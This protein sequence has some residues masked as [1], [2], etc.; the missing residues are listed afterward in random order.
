MTS[1]TKICYKYFM[2]KPVILF[3]SYPDFNGN[4]LAI[5]EELVKRRYD[6]K[7][8]LVWAVYSDFNLKTSYK[9]VKFF[10]CNS[11]EKQDIIRR[12]KCIIDS[13]RYIPKFSKLVY[14]F[15]VRHGCCL[16]NSVVYNRSVGDLD[17]ILTT[18]DEMLKLDQQI[19]SPQIRNKFAVLGMPVTDKLF[20]PKDMYSNGF[21]KELTG[22]G[23]KF[24]KIISWLPTYR[25]HRFKHFS[26]NRF[27]FGIPAVHNIKEYESINETLKAKNALLIIQM[28][29]AQAKNYKQLPNCS[30]IVFINEQ[31]KNKY[32]ISTSDI[33]GNSD[34]LLT[35]YSAAYH[36]FIILNRP[37]GLIIEDLV[38][39]S[40]VQGFFCN[41]LEWIKGD[42]IIDNDTLIEWISNVTNGIDNS[43][44]DRELSLNRI[45]K[46]KDDN[47]SKRVVD[48]LIE[49]AKL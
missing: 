24:S 18:S 9:V 29:H 12:T 36:E 2:A 28:H 1:S 21:L 31:I 4:A 27:P 6:E 34:A 14:R 43:K 13:N 25:D 35:D 23:E 16:K 15:H 22:Q 45:H 33:L 19:W 20:H 39:Y 41:Y 49:K 3:E 40:K 10:N 46:Y 30:N 37:I 48:F 5:Y 47:A 44:I 32:G 7:Y 8:D 42:Y 38:P 26:T 11:A 17:A